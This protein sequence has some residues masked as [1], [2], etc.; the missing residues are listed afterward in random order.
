LVACG[1]GGGSD[2]GDIDLRAAYDRVVEGMNEKDV[3]RAVGRE[4]ND[5]DNRYF[6]WSDG[7][8]Q[9]LNVHFRDDDSGIVDTVRWDKL[10]APTGTLYKQFD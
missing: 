6:G 9:L 2:S 7:K 3:I 8:G 10:T 5:L 4:P 1:G